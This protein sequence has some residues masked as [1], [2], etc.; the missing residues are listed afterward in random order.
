M[1]VWKIGKNYETVNGGSVRIIADDRAS[2]N[3]KHW[4]G[5]Y[6]PVG[7]GEGEWIVTL[8]E[9]GTA[10][11]FD[12][13]KPELSI[14]P[15]TNKWWVLTYTN[16]NF[17]GFNSSPMTN[18]GVRAEIWSADTNSREAIDKRIKNFHME[19]AKVTLVEQ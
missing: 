19:N 3:G 6:T 11:V 7:G 17:S 2:F 5:L 18:S 14:K 15:E 1:K 4:V 8:D 13:I 10:Y 12:T 9:K 16:G